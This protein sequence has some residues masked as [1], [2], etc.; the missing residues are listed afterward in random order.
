MLLKQIKYAIGYG[1]LFGV[2]SASVGAITVGLVYP[3]L[4]QYL[5]GQHKEVAY[6]IFEGIIIGGIISGAI[7]GSRRA[8]RQ[9]AKLRQEEAERRQN[10]EAA[11][12]QR[13]R[14]EQEG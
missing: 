10:E 7:Y 6:V 8:I 3:I 14:E 4:L 12:L 11:R 1:L 13:H 5:E 2:V 9:E